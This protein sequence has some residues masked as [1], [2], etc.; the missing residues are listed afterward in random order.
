MWTSNDERRYIH[1]TLWEQLTHNKTPVTTG[2]KKGA[3]KATICPWRTN[4]MTTNCS[5][6]CLGSC[7]HRDHPISSRWLWCVFGRHTSS[8]V[9]CCS[10]VND[11]TAGTVAHHNNGT[12]STVVV[13][14]SDVGSSIHKLLRENSSSKD[15]RMGGVDAMLAS[16]DWSCNCGCGPFRPLIL[17]EKPG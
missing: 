9:Y 16:V 5:L 14:W 6:F 8:W 1:H 15:S 13:R 4:N 11:P 17:N 7:G 10:S 12:W 2:N 3:N